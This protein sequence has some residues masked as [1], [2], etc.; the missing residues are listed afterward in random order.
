MTEENELGFIV[1]EDQ[2]ERELPTADGWQTQYNRNLWESWHQGFNAQKRFPD[3]TVDNN[4]YIG[5]GGSLVAMTRALG[6]E[7]GFIA[8][9][10]GS[11]LDD[12]P[13]PAS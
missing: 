10:D 13:Y 11:S 5:R 4:P 12:C 3:M 6:W 2:T 9:R 7:D 1:D 8:A